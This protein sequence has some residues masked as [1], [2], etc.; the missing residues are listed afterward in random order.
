MSLLPVTPPPQMAKDA[1]Q[2][3]ILEMQTKHQEGNEVMAKFLAAVE[4][5]GNN[6]KKSVVYNAIGERG[7]RSLTSKR[8]RG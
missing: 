1:C 4:Q 6:A 3:F 2:D 5:R 7:K 8:W